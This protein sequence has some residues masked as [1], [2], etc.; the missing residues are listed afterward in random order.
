LEPA[1]QAVGLSHSYAISRG[2][3]LALDG[4]EL[5]V[6]DGEFL[7]VVGPSGCGKS[8]LLRILGGLVAPSQGQVMLGG[9]PLRG[10][11]RQIGFVFQTA[12]LMPWRTALEN[13]T[14]PLEVAGLLAKEAESRARELLRL[15]GLEGF[16]TARPRELSGGMAQRVAIARALVGDPQVLLLDEPFGALDALSR[17]QMN[18]ELLRIWQARQVTTVMV[19][20]N[21]QEAV[22][23]ADRVAVMS[24]R[25]G[26]I[27]GE[28]RVDLPRPRTLE[29]M[30]TE[31]FT[32]YAR[33]VRDAIGPSH[34]GAGR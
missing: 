34:D 11:L 16:E 33:R 15:V 6:H 25:P 27:R 13:V 21:L 29:V 10:P 1:L 4:V 12:N 28:I 20:H 32:A 18:L 26:R 17:E 23:L 31:F 14:L 5:A 9:R 30:Y 3:L 24:Q 2:R 8:T 7:A 22:F 19:T